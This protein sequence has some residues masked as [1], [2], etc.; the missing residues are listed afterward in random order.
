MRKL[1]KPC[2]AQCNWNF[3]T[4][5]PLAEP[6]YVSCMRLGAILEELSHDSINRLL[7]R[8]R[9]CPEDLF[10]DVKGELILEGGTL[11]VDDTVIDKLY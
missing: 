11:S 8:E 7:L 9:Y 6:K 4:L 3:Y 5:F 10:N 1:S 2:T